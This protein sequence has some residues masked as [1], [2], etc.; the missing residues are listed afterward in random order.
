M[1]KNLNLEAGTQLARAE[2]QKR[3]YETN[4]DYRSGSDV[5]EHEDSQGFRKTLGYNATYN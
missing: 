3:R 2:E 1:V 4:F 5:V